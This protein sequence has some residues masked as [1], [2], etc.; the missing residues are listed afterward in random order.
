MN[1]KSHLSTANRR[2]FL[3]KSTLAA[4]GFTIMP[5]GSLFGASA[6]SNRL[7]IALIG[8]HGRAKAH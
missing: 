5:S 7:N 3:K 8:A 1:T 4:A 6:A 2:D